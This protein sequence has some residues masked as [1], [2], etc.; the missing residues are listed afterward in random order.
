M[1]YTNSE[2]KTIH[3]GDYIETPRFLKV[4]IQMVCRSEETARK[5]GFVEPTHFENDK[6]GILGKMIGENSMNFVAYK[7]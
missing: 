5:Q 1:K 3:K 2:T 4:K 6:Y 7:K